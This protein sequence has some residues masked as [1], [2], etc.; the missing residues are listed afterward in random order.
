MKI[1]VGIAS[2]GCDLAVGLLPIISE[3]TSYGATLITSICN[4]SAAV[5]QKHIF[6]TAYSKGFDLLLMLDS[7]VTVPSYVLPKLIESKK[8]LISAPVW[9]YDPITEDIHLN[10]SPFD[11]INI[12]KYDYGE[13][14]EAITTSSFA[15]LLIAKDVL[16]SFKDSK[17]DFFE[18]SNLLEQ[19]WKNTASDNIFFAKARKLGIQAYVD[20]TIRDCRH[21]CN[22]E[23]SE[24]VIQ[25]LMSR[26]VRNSNI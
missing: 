5:G 24:K 22:V 6:D 20:W 16:T 17:E 3:W 26:K 25:K 9:H 15:C 14:I 18:W 13:G 19:K 1:A 21:Y 10:A 2:R 4:Y 11:D 7:D 23:L 12:R 8:S